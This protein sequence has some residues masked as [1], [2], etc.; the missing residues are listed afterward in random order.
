M[1]IARSAEGETYERNLLHWN[2]L[3][4]RYD[5]IA[6]IPPVAGRECAQVRSRLTEMNDLFE[7]AFRMLTATP[8]RHA[9]STENDVQI[10]E[11]PRLTEI[12]RITIDRADTQ[13]HPFVYG[14]LLTRSGWVWTL[15]HPFSGGGSPSD[16]VYMSF[17]GGHQ[18][19]PLVYRHPDTTTNATIAKFAVPASSN[20][21]A[22]TD[23]GA[24]ANPRAKFAIAEVGM[25][26]L[27]TP[28]H[29]MGNG[30]FFRVDVTDTGRDLSLVGGG[31]YRDNIVTTAV[32]DTAWV[33]S[34]VPATT[35]S[36]KIVG[37]YYHSGVNGTTGGFASFSDVPRQI[38]DTI[39]SIIAE[40]CQ[41]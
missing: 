18:R 28:P 27:V 36:G 17:V 14:V 25:P 10:D 6:P 41:E 7:I 34:G 23:E 30:T 15:S 11:S 26:L 2:I 39:L 40:A 24:A 13:D 35:I 9:A 20:D 19:F 22:P 33:N 4:T 38:G 16:T 8:E 1:T 32:P 31:V 29:G 12:V 5:S 3:A 37:L 21:G